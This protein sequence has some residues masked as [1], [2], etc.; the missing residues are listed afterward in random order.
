MVSRGQPF[1]R[2]PAHWVGTFDPGI[3]FT[4]TPTRCIM[5]NRVLATAI[6]LLHGAFSLI[7]VFGGL[8]ALRYPS[9]LWVHAACVAWAVLTMTTDLGC[10][11]TTWEK[12]LWRRGAR[13]PYTAG[14]VEHYIAGPL[15]GGT[16]SHRGHVLLGALVLGGNLV[17]YYFILRRH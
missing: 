16:V 7:V 6:A 4:R 8:L 1:R 2:V 14:F 12:A 5:L 10:V 3:T 11:L 17:V 15:V 9:L 13:E